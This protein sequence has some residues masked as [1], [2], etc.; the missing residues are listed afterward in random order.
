[1]NPSYCRIRL[2]KD[3]ALVRFAAWNGLAGVGP[4]IETRS[5]KAIALACDEAG[6]WRGRGVFVSELSGWTLFQDLSG[7]LSGL[8]AESWREFAGSHELVFA[9]YNDAIC[10]GELVVIRGGEIVRWFLAQRDCSEMNV[11][12]GRLENERQP[13]D[14]IAVASFIDD[15]EL[16]FCD[17]GWL[18]LF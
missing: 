10:S 6:H 16:A 14:W 5:M 18:W 1:M 7:A 2:P 3:E 13:L 4:L 9:G 11:D 12:V 8:D 17:E 15:D